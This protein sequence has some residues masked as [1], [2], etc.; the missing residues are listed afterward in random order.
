MD[1]YILCT[2]YQFLKNVRKSVHSTQ[3][4]AVCSQPLSSACSKIPLGIRK[5]PEIVALS[6]LSL[7]N[8]NSHLPE[9]HGNTLRLLI[10]LSEPAKYFTVRV[11]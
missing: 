3:P 2:N 1:V 7:P 5:D 10:N 4:S 9:F 8:R 11:F 6:Q